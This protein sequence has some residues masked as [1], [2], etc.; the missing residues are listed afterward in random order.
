[1][2]SVSAVRAETTE[3]SSPLSST[4][5]ATLTADSPDRFINREVSWLDFNHRVVEEAENVA[6][7]MT[8]SA[9]KR[10][11]AD[12]ALP[13]VSHSLGATSMVVSSGSVTN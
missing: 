11:I 3:L 13:I 4:G 1:M 6:A 10:S 12:F 9:I 2:T 5:A 8:C 7:S